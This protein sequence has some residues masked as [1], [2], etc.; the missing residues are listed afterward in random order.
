M[1]EEIDIR[2]IYMVQIRVLSFC[3]ITTKLNYSFKLTTQAGRQFICNIQPS[4]FHKS[5][6]LYHKN[7]YPISY[8]QI[9]NQVKASR[10]LL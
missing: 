6:K 8:I 3:W 9:F 4:P 1:V 2:N 5:V 10:L 7:D